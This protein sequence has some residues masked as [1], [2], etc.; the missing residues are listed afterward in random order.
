MNTSTIDGRSRTPRPYAPRAIERPEP[1]AINA[2]LGFN[3]PDRIW[4]CEGL[5]MYAR[6]IAVEFC[7]LSR[8]GEQSLDIPN[9]K[10]MKLTGVGRRTVDETMAELETA[11]LIYRIS[12]GVGDPIGELKQLQAI[13]FKWSG[14]LPL[15]LIVL[16]WNL[17]QPGE[18]PDDAFTSTSA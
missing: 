14:D 18:T 6:G 1:K 7:R 15:R 16:L 5:S 12:K 3:V 9:K 17:P 2:P 11:G 8:R 10:L 13:G 4:R